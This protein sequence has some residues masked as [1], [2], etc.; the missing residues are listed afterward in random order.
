MLENI[1]T[2]LLIKS[3]WAIFVLRASLGILLVVHGWSK[4]KDVRGTAGWFGSVGFRPGMLWAVVGTIVEL[5]GG[6][7][8]ALGLFVRCVAFVVA[9]QFAVILLWR[10]KRRDAFVGAIELDLMIFASALVLL[11]QGAGELALGNYL[12]GWLAGWLQ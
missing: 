10:L 6:T 1:S 2:L 4:A 11:S 3:D 12:R 7:L 9:G 8:L 5:G